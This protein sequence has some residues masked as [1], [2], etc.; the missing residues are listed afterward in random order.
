MHGKTYMWLN[1]HLTTDTA[2]TNWFSELQ[3]GALERTQVSQTSVFDLI[4]SQINNNTDSWRIWRLPDVRRG[5]GGYLDDLQLHS[6][7]GLRALEA[8]ADGFHQ[9]VDEPLAR[10][11]AVRG[12]ARDV[13]VRDQLLPRTNSAQV[14][15][16]EAAWAILRVVLGL[17]VISES[18]CGVQC[19]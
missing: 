18:L 15:A 1:P 4:G 3:R 8:V 6:L 16:A 13:A 17:C 5:A 7:V 2:C 12:I 9:P 10:G 19:T 11:S 14:R